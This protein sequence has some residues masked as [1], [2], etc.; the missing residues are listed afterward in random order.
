MW[1]GLTWWLVS[2]LKA[3]THPQ[4]SLWKRIALAPLALAATAIVYIVRAVGHALSYSVSHSMPNVSHWMNDLATREMAINNAEANFAEQTA[5][6][7]ER[8]VDHTIPIE[9]RHETAP[10]RHGIDHLER[11]LPRLRARLEHFRVGI[12]RLLRENIMPRVRANERA[13]DIAIPREIGR[14]RTRVKTVERT[15]SN[16]SRS[17]VK[18]MWK[19]GWLAIGAGL[20]LK[21]LVRKFP[22]LFCRNTT[23][24]LKALCGMDSLLLDALLLETTA[25]VGSISVVQFAEDLQEV[26]DEAVT[27]LRGLIQE[28]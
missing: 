9:I 13:I 5:R 4:G 10:L 7:F 24:G 21:F 16:P 19:Y 6:S 8:L 14:I 22:H 23:R 28:L 1:A 20:V 3:F 27:L 17:W 18:R 26:E 2:M 11:D 15:I 12:D 25:I